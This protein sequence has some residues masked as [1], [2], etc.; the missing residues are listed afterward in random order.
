MPLAGAAVALV[1]AVGSVLA[2]AAAAPQAPSAV[3]D[4]VVGI[5]RP[6]P[7]PQPWPAEA[8]PSQTRQQLAERT[9][10]DLVGPQWE[11]PK[12]RPMVR[13]VW[14]TLGALS[15][16]DYLTTITRN[17]PG[18]E[19]NAAP[20]SGWA[21]GDWGLTRPGA[22]TIDMAKWHEPY[23]AGDRGRLA[24]LLVH[25]LGHAY[26]RTPEA[27]KAY[28]H[29]ESLYARTGNFSDYGRGSANENFSEVVG[30][31]VARCAAKNP[32]D[33]AVA[34]HG[35]FDAYYALVRDEVFDGREFGP[36]VGRTPDC[37]VG[38]ASPAARGVVRADKTRPTTRTAGAQVT[39]V[40][41]E[42]LDR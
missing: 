13:I 24:R 5:P 40:P 41:K 28:T 1:V 7:S 16:T 19:L 34:N 35:Q 11:E 30:Y 2:P 15:C 3:G 17:H 27:Q 31:Y 8:S 29:F 6:C 21:F 32:Y 23:A 26:A 20:I 22:V 42:Q 38:P 25:E 37:A 39:R 12:N 18:F 14:E 36:K 10:I 9:G 4:P 33:S